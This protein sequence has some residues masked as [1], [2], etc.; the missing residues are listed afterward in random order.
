MPYELSRIFCEPFWNFFQANVYTSVLVGTESFRRRPHQR[1]VQNCFLGT[2]FENHWYGKDPHNWRASQGLR[3]GHSRPSFKASFIILNH[4]MLQQPLKRGI[5][6]GF[7][8]RS[9][10]GG[11][12]MYI[13][14]PQVTH[15]QS[16]AELTFPGQE[17]NS[18]W[19]SDNTRSLTHWATR[20]LPEQNIFM[21]HGP[22]VLA[23]LGGHIRV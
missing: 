7:L 16:V 2:P 20:E 17:S 15:I 22:H 10:K 19:D 4:F 6:L 21:C 9:G 14:F 11:L 1:P 23:T 5:L 3:E 12:G 13:T 18:R 8:Y